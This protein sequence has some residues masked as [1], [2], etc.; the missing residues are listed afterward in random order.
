MVRQNWRIELV[1]G[2]PLRETSR[3]RRSFGFLRPRRPS[4][5]GRPPLTLEVA[6]AEVAVGRLGTFVA[7]SGENP[8]ALVGARVYSVV[9]AG[10][11][12]A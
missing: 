3:G 7:A 6:A 10:A 2:W 11:G 9:R 5:S 8:D 4:V 12:E 1:R